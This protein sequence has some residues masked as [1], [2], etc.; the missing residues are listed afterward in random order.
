MDKAEMGRKY[1]IS[2]TSLYRWMRGGRLNKYYCKYRKTSLLSEWEV[3]C[4]IGSRNR[5]IN[6]VI[7]RT[8]KNIKKTV[9]V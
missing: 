2:G 8:C 4:Y 1:G 3:L 6:K 5:E 9:S 7:K